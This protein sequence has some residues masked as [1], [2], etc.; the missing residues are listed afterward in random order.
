MYIKT[1]IFIIFIILIS[2]SSA[3]EAGWLKQES[4]TTNNLNAVQMLNT[5]TAIVCGDNGSLL[6]TINKGITWEDLE[7]GTNVNLNDV[8]F[9]QDAG[10]IVGESG[11]VLRLILSYHPKVA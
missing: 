3:Q 4:G 5:D 1:I 6:K 9:C 8:T 7:T 10:Y 11:T 2:I